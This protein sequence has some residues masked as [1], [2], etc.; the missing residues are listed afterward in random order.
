LPESLPPEL[1][2]GFTWRKANPV[3]SLTLL[4]RHAELLGLAGVAFLSNLAHVVLPSTAVLYA[5][6]RYGW[7]E[8][9]L[10]IMLA[11]VGICSLLVQVGLVGPFVKYF[12]ER[13]A[14]VAGLL[15]GAVGF[16]IYGGAP[17][18]VI[19]CAGVP[20][21]ALWGLASP[22]LQSLMTRHVSASEQ[23]QLQGANGSLM[24][25]ASLLGPSLFTL[26]FA[27]AIAKGQ[28]W[29]PIG[30]PFLLAALIMVVSTVMAWRVTAPRLSGG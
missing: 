14:L 9:T 19:F 26:S 2:S 30:T 6:Y 10:G 15:F 25:I 8:A 27:Y 1:R 3:G 13:T 29:M 16:T 21:M 5:G 20:V 22:A 18:G 24:G 28:A 4:R 17:T 7:D 11:G 23:G 12:G